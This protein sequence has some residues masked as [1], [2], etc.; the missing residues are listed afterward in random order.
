MVGNA[1]DTL[2]RLMITEIL[3]YDTDLLNYFPYNICE[4]L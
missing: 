4:Y 1:D 3:T 2:F